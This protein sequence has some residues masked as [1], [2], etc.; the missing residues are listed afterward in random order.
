[1]YIYL[2]K[3][4]EEEKKKGTKGKNSLKKEHVL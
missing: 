3:E 4:K 1:M 2:T